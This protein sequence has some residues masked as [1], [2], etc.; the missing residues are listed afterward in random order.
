MDYATT[1]DPIQEWYFRIRE[2]ALVMPDAHYW[3]IFRMM[4]VMAFPTILCGYAFKNGSRSMICQLVCLTAGIF[5][6]LIIPFAHPPQHPDIK[7]FTLVFSAILLAVIP[8]ILPFF[9]TPRYG[10]QNKLRIIL[11]CGLGIVF[12]VEIL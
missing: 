3:L 2:W 4:M 12:L 7:A 8:A 11:Y 1:V 5:G 9:L 6:A 10:L